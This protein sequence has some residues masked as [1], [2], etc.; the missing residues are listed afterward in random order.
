MGVDFTLLTLAALSLAPTVETRYTIPLA[1]GV[2]YAPA[3]VFIWATVMTALLSV[4]L[5]HGLWLFDRLVRKTPVLSEIWEKYIDR[6]RKRAEPYIEKYGAPGLIFFVAV[7]LP[8]TGVWTGSLVGYV[9]GMN[10]KH[11]MMYTFIGGLIANVITFLASV[12][13]ISLI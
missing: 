6:A 12:G 7:P 2:G 5:A 11:M 9:L 1:I 4:M 10:A 13:V 3:L 8:G